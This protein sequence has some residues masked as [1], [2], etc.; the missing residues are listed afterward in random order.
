MCFQSPKAISGDY[1]EC[2]NFGCPKAKQSDEE[3]CGG[4][5]YYIYYAEIQKILHLLLSIL[6]I[7]S[8]LSLKYSALFYGRQTVNINFSTN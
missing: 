6:I 3:E 4:T 7:L 1:C 8:A 5:H 2:K